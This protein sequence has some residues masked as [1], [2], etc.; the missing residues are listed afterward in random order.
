MAQQVYYFIWV[1]VFM[2]PA[3]MF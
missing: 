3:F 1:D 2:N